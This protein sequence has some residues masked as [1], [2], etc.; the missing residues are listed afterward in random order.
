M[1]YYGG[2]ML[3][4]PR[5]PRGP[6][7][8]SG[9]PGPACRRASACCG[10]AAGLAG[11][12]AA[13]VPLAA[14][15]L[16]R[17]AAGSS[18]VRARSAGRRRAAGGA[19]AQSRAGLVPLAL[20]ALYAWGVARSTTYTITNRRVVIRIGMALPLTDQPAVRPH[21]RRRLPR[22]PDGSGDI[23]LQLA[24]GDRLAY[25]VLWPHARPLAPA[26]A[27]P[28]L[29][30]LPDAAQA[31]QILA[32]ALA[33]SADTHAGALGSCSRTATT[34]TIPAPARSR[35]DARNGGGPTRSTRSR[36]RW[37]FRL[38]GDDRRLPVAAAATRARAGAPPTAGT[39][40]ATARDC[41]SRTG[42]TARCWSMTGAATPVRGR[43]GR[44]R[45]PARHAARPGPHP[46]QRGHRRPQ[47]F[48]LSAWRDGRLTL[49][50]PATGRHV[51]L[52]AFGADQRRRV[53]ALPA[54]VWLER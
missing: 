2:G 4:R 24:R 18:A 17:R 34:G 47:P 54:P 12:G 15:G 16:F 19:R 3:L 51:E 29:R 36:D 26:P 13:R 38:L 1:A 7:A 40:L 50:D 31:A 11:A 22:R 33:A 35:P 30:A 52:E 32:R 46:A 44:E 49:D 6:A 28:M 8:V 37:P 41:G 42:R 53:R 23:A 9:L 10:R 5:R 48:H 43:G 21:R 45:L 20:L 14:G 27:E 39:T 25:V